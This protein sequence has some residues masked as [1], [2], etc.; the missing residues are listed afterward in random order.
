MDNPYASVVV[1][2][3]LGLVIFA[4]AFL[5]IIKLTPFSVRHEIEEDHNTALAII[6]GSVILGVSLTLAAAIKG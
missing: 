6:I 5:A 3:L 2:G 1:F 4:I